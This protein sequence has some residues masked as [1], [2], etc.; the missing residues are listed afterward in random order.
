M[1]SKTISTL[2]VS[3][4]ALAL[5]CGASFIALAQTTPAA[6]SGL[7]AEEQ[8]RAI[9]LAANMSNKLDAAILRFE[10]ISTRLQSRIIKMETDGYNMAL[11]WPHLSAVN[12]NME[13]ARLLMGGMPSIA[14]LVASENP[15]AEW[16]A[17]RGKFLEVKAELQSAKQSL[18]LTITEMKAAAAKGPQ[19]GPDGT[20]AADAPIMQ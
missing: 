5:F 10:T 19:A 3:G 13:Q 17:A 2:L 12:K 16:A 7:T 11:I 6:Q 18:M 14:E 4:F 15:K 1:Q 20:P 8:T 9:N